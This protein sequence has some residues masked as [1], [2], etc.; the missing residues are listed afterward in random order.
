MKDLNSMANMGEGVRLDGKHAHDK[1][2]SLKAMKIF[3]HYAEQQVDWSEF[4]ILISAVPK[5]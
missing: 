4:D 2:M 1:G 3:L 5:L